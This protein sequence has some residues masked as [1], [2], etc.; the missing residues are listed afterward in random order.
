MIPVDE[1]A[2]PNFVDFDQV[3]D[4]MSLGEDRYQVNDDFQ[5]W[6]T[7]AWTRD[8]Q[9]VGE[10]RGPGASSC[11]SD[12]GAPPGSGTWVL[13]SIDGECQWLDTTTCS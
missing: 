2:Q 3:D 6:D 7:N 4:E 12:A 9:D 11:L 13:G 10:V 1:D 8:T 5:Q